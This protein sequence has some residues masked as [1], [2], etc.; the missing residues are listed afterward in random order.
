MDFY[1]NFKIDVKPLENFF[2]VLDSEFDLKIENLSIS[3]GTGPIDERSKLAG[4]LSVKLV[5]KIFA[6][7]STFSFKLALSDHQLSIS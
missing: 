3:Y 7:N 4:G 5:G 1:S 6:Y 2:V